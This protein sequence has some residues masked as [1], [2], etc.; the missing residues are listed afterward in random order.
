M[1]DDFDSQRDWMETTALVAPGL[2]GAA[3]GMLVGD[4]MHRSARRGV[5]IALG[6]LGIATL[7]PLLVGGIANKVNGPSSARGVRR[8]I[9]GIR[10]AGDGMP[11]YA[12]DVD[13]ELREQ[14]I[15]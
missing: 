7:M 11:G 9:A 4:L 12:L 5:A 8:R 1:A 13:D 2:L 10:D 3:V 14:G 15:L 6:G